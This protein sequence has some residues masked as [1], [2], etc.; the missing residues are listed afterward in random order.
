MFKCVWIEQSCAV[1]K[2]EGT[3]NGVMWEGIC[4]YYNIVTIIFNIHY[5]PGIMLTTAYT[6]SHLLLKKKKRRQCH[7][8]FRNKKHKAERDAAFQNLKG[9]NIFF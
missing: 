9:C 1:N 5:V 8:H 2:Y 4:D 3:E 6:L 7:H